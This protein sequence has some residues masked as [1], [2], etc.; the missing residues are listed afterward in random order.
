MDSFMDNGLFAKEN[1]ILPYI[2]TEEERSNLCN[3]LSAG[4]LEA[5]LD[6]I[7]IAQGDND[8]P[9]LNI[10]EKVCLVLA[11][12]DS[13]MKKLESRDS[14]FS[15][16]YKECKNLTFNKFLY[17]LPKNDSQYDFKSS[18][19]KYLE[20][21]EEI[22]FCKSKTHLNDEEMSRL[23]SIMEKTFIDDKEI[24][25]EDDNFLN[26]IMDESRFQCWIAC[27]LTSLYYI[28]IHEEKEQ[29][30]DFLFKL[31]ILSAKAGVENNKSLYN[32][33]LKVVGRNGIRNQ[34]KV[35]SQ[36][37]FEKDPTDRTILSVFLLY[38]YQKSYS[39]GGDYLF[40]ELIDF[41]C[42][43]MVKK[44]N[45]E[46]FLREH[47]YG[48]V[49]CE[50][51]K[52][53]CSSHQIE[54]RININS[55]LD[56]PLHLERDKPSYDK[57]RYYKL[58]KNRFNNCNEGL[59]GEYA[60]LSKLYNA[61]KKYGTP[62][63]DY[64]ELFIY[65][66][67][68]IYQKG[69]SIDEKYSSEIK[70]NWEWRIKQTLPVIVR[71]LYQEGKNDKIPY[72]PIASYFGIEETNGFSSLCNKIGEKSL[73]SFRAMLTDCGFSGFDDIVQQIKD[74]KDNSK[75]KHQ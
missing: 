21:A 19:R 73:N 33:W 56:M 51:Y 15:R 57:N 70:M 69:T 30:P 68:G 49:F 63:D 75:N 50:E 71:L 20:S 23:L 36:K 38:Y 6:I 65:R 52:S 74:A 35:H 44:L 17:E 4:G 58:N 60:A 26:S 37:L 53:Y 1:N 39:D 47:Q 3:E 40:T 28:S 14:I 32:R 59:D 48:K 43:T 54:P 55:I 62:S 2:F 42:D 11:D 45:F 67:S 25:K 29:L 12:A 46:E 24:E 31:I 13:Y 64:E 41:Y 9:S 34:I 22:D 10:G 16:F 7:E 61:M 72:K 66:F 5:M 18:W 27:L 8:M